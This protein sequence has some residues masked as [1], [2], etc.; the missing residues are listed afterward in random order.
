MYYQEDNDDSITWIAIIIGLGVFFCYSHIENRKQRENI[1]YHVKNHTRFYELPPTELF[2]WDTKILCQKD[3]Y[4]YQ[5][6]KGKWVI[7]EILG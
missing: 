5:N 6:I 4:L 1:E 3:G 2:P 7:Y